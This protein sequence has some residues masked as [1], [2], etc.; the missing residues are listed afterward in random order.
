MSSVL[1]ICTKATALAPVAKQLLAVHRPG[2]KIVCYQ[3]GIE[4]EH[5]LSDIIGEDDTLR[6]V[7]NHAG[8]VPEDGVIEM[9]FFHKPNYIGAVSEKSNDFAA[10]L[11]EAMTA[12]NVDTEYV[13]D[14]RKYEWQKTILN[15]ALAPVT[16]VTGLT[17]KE[18]MDLPE[19]EAL[20][21]QL[22]REGIA[23]A[24]ALGYDYGN[25]FFDN[26]VQYLRGA[27]HHKPSM[28]VDIEMNNRTEID[29]INGKIVEHGDR[30][31]IPVAA[32]QALYASVK[33]LENL[34][35][36]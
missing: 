11:A 7:I 26:A 33:G 18:A 5:A 30:L 10:R 1:R 8:T 20:V 17:M 14:I 9:T 31:G 25:D 24:K 22:L 2:R 35:R 29:L 3:N 34:M 23:V 32:N 27:G 15:A 19:T 16:A 12:A 28:R 21:K 4:N 6:V 13:S 36:R